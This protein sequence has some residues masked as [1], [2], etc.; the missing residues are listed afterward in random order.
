MSLDSGSFALKERTLVIILSLL[1][2]LGMFSDAVAPASPPS[3]QPRVLILG[4]HEVEP[5]GVPPHVT[6]PREGAKSLAP[7]EMARFTISSEA[8]RSQLDALATHGYTVISLRDLYDFLQGTKPSL[9]ARSVVITTDDGWISAKSE[10]EP[11]LKRRGHPFTVFVYPRVVERH[12]HHPFNLTWQDIESLSKEGVDIQS[13]TFSHPVLSRARHPEM[14]DA[15]YSDWLADELCRS[16][17]LIQ[18]HTGRDVKFLAYPFG[19]Y[20]DAVV[21]AARTA[22]YAAAVTVKPGLVR[23]GADLMT[24]RRFLV[25]HDTLL[26]EFESWLETTK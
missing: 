14:D 6:I 2:S 7:D 4:Y 8:F 11:E 18:L 24:L 5:G 19:E 23:K 1:L 17:E 12:S 26:G 13:H 9:P 20:D 16:R 25:L 3:G 10:M 22:G 21:A 15:Q